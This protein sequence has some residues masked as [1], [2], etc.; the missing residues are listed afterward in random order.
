[1]VEKIQTKRRSLRA[2]VGIGANCRTDT[3]RRAF[4]AMIDLTAAGCCVFG[5]EVVLT[6]G[7]KVTLNPDCLAP[8][9]GT[10]RWSRGSLAGLE[11]ENEL[12]PAVFEHLART[13]PWHP[14]ETAKRALDGQADIPATVQRELVR[15]IGRAEEKFRKRDTHKDVLTTRPLIVS[16]RPGTAPQEADHRLVKLFLA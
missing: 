12:Y 2:E 6:V 16:S 3:G 5:R 1:M 14:S 7:Q 4:M 9:R 10:V 15:M 8:I 11:F 13:H